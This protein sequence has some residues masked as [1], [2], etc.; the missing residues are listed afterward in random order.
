MSDEPSH[1]TLGRVY[2]VGAGPGD[3]GLITVRAANCLARAD[4]VLYDYLVNPQ[5]LDYVRDSAETICLG[6]H[7]RSTIWPQ[8][9]INQRLVDEAQAGRIVV[10]LKGGDPM[11]FGRAADEL[12][13]LV[14]R[15]IPF[16]IVP[17]ITAA[18]AAG[19][20]AGIP[21]THRDIASAVALV[22]GQEQESK[23]EA[24]IDFEAIGRFPGTIVV[25]MGVTTVRRWATGLLRGGKPPDTPVA[26]IRRCSWPNQQVL[27]CRLD[28]VV[29][30][31]TPYHKFAPPAIAIVGP[32]S[33]LSHKLSWFEK[34][35]LF[36]R[37]ILITRPHDQIADLECRLAELGAETIRSPVI[38][39]T[40]PPDWAPVDNVLRRIGEFDW[41]VFSSVNGVRQTLDRL[42]ALGRDMR[43]L[44]QIKIAAIGPATAK[45][46]CRYGLRADLQPAEFRAEALAG[47]LVSGAKGRRFLLARASRGREVLAEELAKS[48]AF[49]EQVV[50]YSSLDRADPDPSVV[51]ALQQGSIDWVTVTSSAIARSFCRLYGEHM[52]STKLASISPITSATLRELGFEAA[53][54]AKVYDMNGLVD[55]I[56]A[57]TG[58]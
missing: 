47:E 11:I 50:V 5:L 13:A 55:S 29:N 53:V 45:A 14:E 10:R 32:V 26:I 40:D 8:S 38:E 16:E 22:T 52:A 28:E 46:L 30:Q 33:E 6:R 19:S 21:V 57:A 56:V 48:G 44:A 25:Y 35:P 18:L 2:L 51:A 54:E 9:A 43:S 49:V 39:I 37:T 34:R 31:L 17:G 24:A 12:D 27:H 36:G 3:P 41:I 7:G 15:G 1:A 23:G 58:R 20:C 42:L 4:V